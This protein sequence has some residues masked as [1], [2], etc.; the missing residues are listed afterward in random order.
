MLSITRA[1]PE[2]LKA[3]CDIEAESFISSPWSRDAI[4]FYMQ[5]K[6][7]EF[8]I[9]RVDGAIAGYALSFSVMDQAELLKIAVLPS[10]RR[11][12]IGQSLLNEILQK[13]YSGEAKELF[14]E[15]RE[16]NLNAMGLYERVGFEITGRRKDY[17]PD[18][19][20]DAVLMRHKKTPEGVTSPPRS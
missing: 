17:Y 9:A 6:D 13:V 11:Q 5:R 16:S 10:M 19:K 8:L 2:H 20:E 7:A 12:G 4:K 14:L 3:I 15:V 1:E 18:T